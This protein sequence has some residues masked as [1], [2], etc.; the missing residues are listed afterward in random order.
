MPKT[1]VAVTVDSEILN[2]LDDLIAQNRFPNRSQAI[3]A[4]L[5]EKLERLSRA[6]LARECAKLDAEEE[7]ALA[8]EGLSSELDTWPAY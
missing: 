6:R 5:A 8:E 3:E 7:K 2:E 4:A 1:K